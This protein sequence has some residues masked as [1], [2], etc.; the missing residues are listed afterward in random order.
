MKKV[1]SIDGGG[2]RGIIPLSCLVQL[3]AQEGKPCHEIF[4]MVAGTSTGSIIACGIALGISARG[5]LALYR[6][7]AMHAFKR[8]PWWEILGN[9]GNHRY[10]AEFISRTLDEIGANIPLNDLDIDILITGK[11][12]VT[13]RTDFFVRDKPSNAALWGNLSL[14]DAVLASI[15]VPSYFPAHQVVHNG[16]D[17]TWVDGGVGVASNPCYH[18]AVEAL[19][20]C[21]DQYSP[22][23]TQ[24]ISFGTGHRPHVI[25]AQTANALKWLEWSLR[26]LLEDIGEWQT[27]VTQ[28]EYGLTKKIDF[29]R[30]QLDLTSD[31]LGSLGIEVSDEASLDK[32]GMDAVWAVDLLEDIGK[33]FAHRIDFS[34]PLGL[35]LETQLS[36]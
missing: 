14:R 26:E 29:R 7:L 1:L 24:L 33:A 21:G 25:H 28:R 32:L 4:D 16:Q 34:D 3:E 22:G 6:N 15:A 19:H 5:M 27:Y 8:L 35:V 30:Y 12:T 9:L 10:S 2:I 20:Y 18:A 36:L 31:V 23:D 13:S 11:N 17:F